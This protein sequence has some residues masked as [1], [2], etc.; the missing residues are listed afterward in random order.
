MLNKMMKKIYKITALILV[1]VLLVLSLASCGKKNA[2]SASGTCESGL[3][4]DYDS[5]TKTLSI[6][7]NG[8]MKDFAKS[9]DAPWASVSASAKTVTVSSGVLKIGAYAFYGFSA[10]ESIS[11]PETVAAMWAAIRF[12]DLS[13]AS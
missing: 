6:S 11:L 10:L 9:S 13:L 4:W 12:T 2:A 1:S 5:E 3:V 8:E 7:G